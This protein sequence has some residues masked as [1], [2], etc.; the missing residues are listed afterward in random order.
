MLAFF[1]ALVQRDIEGM[2][3][4]DDYKLLNKGLHSSRDWDAYRSESAGGWERLGRNMYN[5]S[6]SS[7]R[8][9]PERES[10]H[11]SELEPE[12]ESELA[13]VHGPEIRSAEPEIGLERETESIAEPE[14]DYAPLHEPELA[15]ENEQEAFGLEQSV[16]DESDQKPL[17][18][19]PYLERL[20]DERH[21]K[22]ER[23]APKHDM[24]T[25]LIATKEGQLLR[26]ARNN[27][28]LEA[29]GNPRVKRRHMTLLERLKRLNR[30]THSLTMNLLPLPEP[31]STSSAHSQSETLSV[32]SVSSSS[33]SSEPSSSESDDDDDF[34]KLRDAV[35]PPRVSP[36]SELRKKVRR[37]DRNGSSAR[38]SEA[39]ESAP[40]PSTRNTFDATSP[41]ILKS[42]A[43]LR[44][45]DSR[46]KKR[47]TKRNS[48]QLREEEDEQ[49]STSATARKEMEMNKKRRTAN[50]DSTTTYSSEDPDNRA[51]FIAKLEEVSKRLKRVT[52][53]LTSSA[54]LLRNTRYNNPKKKRQ[55]T[56]IRSPTS[57][58]L[59]SSTSSS[60]KSS[61]A[62]SSSESEESYILTLPEL[63][64]L[65]DLPKLPNPIEPGT[66]KTDS[67]S[68]SDS[69]DDDDDES[70]SSTSTTET[71]HDD[72][73]SSWV[74][75]KIKQ[76][77]QRPS[78]NYR[79]RKE[80]MESDDSS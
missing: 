60:S 27:I 65:P 3:D 69:S 35:Q 18:L 36:N 1:D 51:D 21:E 63:P 79:K 40:Q 74:E 53:D 78:R 38:L 29:E 75:E 71:E 17:K 52:S 62:V 59:S 61:S 24:I 37:F 50:S 57:S 49:P 19:S 56:M 8:A 39:N 70:T 67:E 11:E 72:D 4:E 73:A 44:K 30:K 34:F 14:L 12:R 2:S 16:P 22:Q 80:S 6:D 10:E 26:M 47:P 45:R 46:N 15:S 9:T 77:H 42:Q 20:L 31:S 64:K 48:G 54:S 5:D 23:V 13:P 25:R 32:S 43:R 66:P 7:Y 58:S 68:D 28:K 33:S 76:I 41:S 55:S